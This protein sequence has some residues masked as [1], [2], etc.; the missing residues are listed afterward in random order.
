MKALLVRSLVVFLCT[1]PTGIFAAETE[2]NT[3]EIF[4]KI[5]DDKTQTPVA[6]ASIALLRVADST[7]VTGVI[8]NENGQFRFE[9]VPYGNYKLK[10]SF[11]GYKTSI[12][13]QVN[14]SKQNKKV[15]IKDINLSEE[16]TVLK[17]VVVTGERLKGEEKIDRTVF[18]IND[19]IVRTSQS[20][21]DVLKQIPAVSVDFQ[22][23]VSLAGKSDIQFYVDGVLR[24]KNYVAQ[25][26]PK[27]IDKV[28]TL[29]NPG[30][31]YNADISGVINIVMKKEKRTG[32]NGSIT[33]VIPNPN[34]IVAEPNAN[35]EWGNKKFRV[36][37]SDRFHFEK[38]NG[39]ENLTTENSDTTNPYLFKR[40]SKGI[41]NWRNNYTNYGVDWFINDKTSLSFLGEWENQTNIK[42]D[43]YNL[44]QTYE[45]N[46]LTNYLTTNQNSKYVRNANLLSLFLKRK[47]AQEGSEI[48][49]EANIYLQSEEGKNAYTDRYYYPSD[50][51]MLKDSLTR[52]DLSNSN[53]DVATVKADYTFTLKNIKNETGIRF[54]DQWMNNDFSN[55]LADYTGEITQTFKYSERREAA[56]YNLTGKIKNI[57]WQAGLR[58]EVSNINIE[59]TTDVNY[60]AIL[61][62]VSL[63][64]N[65]NKN[66]SL[67]IT[68]RKKINRPF[69]TDLN[70]FVTWT[71]SLHVR[72]GNPDLK[73]AYENTVELAYSKNIGSNFLS[74]KIYS[75]YTK[76]SIQDLTVVSDK[77]IT[78][79]TRANIGKDFEYGV[80]FTA[81][82]QLFKKW[83]INADMSLGNHIVSS[84][85]GLALSDRTEK[86]CYRINGSTSV[87]LPKKFSVFAFAYYNSPDISYQRESSRDLLFLI[88]ADKQLGEKA[89]INVIYNPFIHS[90]KYGAVET[91]SPGYHESWQ[92]H[93]DAS[94]LFIIELTYNF[95]TGSKVN[96]IDRGV[97]VEKGKSG[98]SF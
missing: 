85:Q 5:I 92:G 59:D 75:R 67:K 55:S 90:F 73:P 88:G 38:F 22:N 69:I 29:T 79:V 87:E 54:S 7:L 30:V 63:S 40:D 84:D 15:E 60:A 50:I 66:Q 80:A 53:S 94:N 76:N 62:Q 52:G 81:A 68:Y 74:P 36:Y 33:A 31:K 26:D 51:S 34:C 42:N 39:T 9:N 24:D 97:D 1:L 23:N 41:N 19:Q 96:K 6:Y 45:N 64:R 32:L 3:G 58:G 8:T 70:P 12:L 25:L 82:I 21:L 83:R 71:D 14:L 89:K 28:E 4:G 95:N 72:L 44:S 56:Y 17:D 35:L 98:G 57:N 20:G 18:T 78:Q 49:T 2:N 11:V 37:A 93:V 91:T 65:F 48:T 86:V 61:P 43:Y 13:N 77:G 46:Q 10:A 47:L 27:S 16:A